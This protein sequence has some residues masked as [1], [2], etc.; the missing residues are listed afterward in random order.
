MVPAYVGY[1]AINALTGITRSWLMG[2]GHCVAAIDAT[3]LIVNN[4]SP[5]QAKRYAL[6]DAGLKQ[7]VCDFYSYIAQNSR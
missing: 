2:Q 7:F 4:M 1:L 6:T 5:E 3:N